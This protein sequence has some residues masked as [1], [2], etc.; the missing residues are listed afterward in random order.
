MYNQLVLEHIREDASCSAL[1]E[2]NGQL[3][4]SLEELGALG[5]QSWS[6][7]DQF[8]FEHTYPSLGPVQPQVVVLYG[9]LGSPE[10]AALHDT[11]AS[12]ATE[13]RITYIFRHYTKPSAAR[14][15]LSG[16]GVQL[17]IKSTEYKAVDDRQV[18]EGTAPVV[19]KSNEEEEVEGFLFSKLKSLHPDIS[20]KLDDFRTHLIRSSRELPDLKAWQLQDLGLQAAQRVVSSGPEQALR[21][22]RDLAQNL[23]V[24]AR[25]LWRSQV[26]SQLRSE[27][28]QNQQTLAQ[29]GVNPGDVV[30]QLNSIV[31]RDED[32]DV[33]NLQDVLRSEA[34]LITGFQ[35]LRIPTL[36][37]QSLLR[38][39]GRS[40]NVAFG[41]DI[42]NESVI[43][44]LQL[45]H[46]EW[47]HWLRQPL[48]AKSGTKL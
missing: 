21:V 5:N 19:S 4:C 26:D 25:S 32:L 2:A 11:L 40:E 12:M 34:S 45:G 36:H 17:A 43:T 42:R 22:L 41:L 27:V 48:P 18:Q 30:L 37:R 23:P 9:Q 8:R 1:V 46:L 28:Q 3:A 38:L 16:Y 10:F 6:V 47:V 33:F 29:I 13:G 31:L 20:D 44:R 15:R 39:S 7:P 24:Q 35:S 14:T